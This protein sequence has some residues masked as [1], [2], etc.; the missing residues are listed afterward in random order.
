MFKKILLTVLILGLM[1]GVGYAG[2]VTDDNNG[3]KGDIF[4]ST[5]EN[6]GANSV[7]EWVDSSAF[8]GEKGDK[9]DT[10][11]T[12]A[13][14]ATGEQGPAG[15][16]GIDGLNGSDG[17]D[18]VD[19]K[20]GQN[21]LD[22]RDGIDGAVG[23][24]GE[25]GDTGE[26][27]VAGNDGTNG[28]DGKNGDKGDKGDTGSQGEQG[29]QGEQG[30]KGDIGLTGATGEKG[31]TGDTGSKG[32]K[33]D[34]GKEG[35]KGEQG[36]QGER[37]KGLEDR[38]EVI[39]EIRILD[40]RK[41]TTSI[42]AGRDINNDVNIVGVKF[43]YKLGRSYYEKKLDALEARVNNLV[44]EQ[45]TETITKDKDGNVVSIHMSN[46]DKGANFTHSF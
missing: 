27:G 21:G 16:D 15:R 1:V 45:V 37:G 46:N 17:R 42:Y 2:G 39:G 25:K 5:G 34:E 12:G 11:A 20:D 4:V 28:Q 3:N 26:Q 22:G 10:G 19:G 7:G 23:P 24:Q 18:G 43:T 36:I 31:N 30:V 9:G 8:K 40:T 6:H 38:Y 35:K 29:I 14:G 33:G 44:P 13:T 41:T 32:D